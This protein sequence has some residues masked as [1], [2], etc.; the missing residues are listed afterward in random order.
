LFTG[1]I[2]LGAA[3]VVL[4]VP[5]VLSRFITPGRTYPLYGLRDWVHRAI[6]RLCRFPSRSTWP[7][8]PFRRRLSLA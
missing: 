5:R 7:L 1:V 4:T 6:G 8:S 2:L 3:A